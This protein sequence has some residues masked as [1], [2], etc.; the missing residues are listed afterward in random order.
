MKKFLTIR[1]VFAELASQSQKNQVVYL[2]NTMT[3]IFN[4][5]VIDEEGN[6]IRNTFYYCRH[7]IWVCKSL[8]VGNVWVS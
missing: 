4:E 1:F 6:N 2:W 3:S 5:P 7:G 8:P